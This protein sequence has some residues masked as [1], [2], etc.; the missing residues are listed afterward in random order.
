MWTQGSSKVMWPG[1]GNMNT[2][3]VYQGSGSDITP[4]T[5]AVFNNPANSSFQNSFPYNGYDVGDYNMDGT[6]IYQGSG[7]DIL[8]LTQA[9]FTNPMNGTYQLTYPISEQ[10]P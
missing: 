8:T 6:V 3:T 2:S 10:L 7:S 9:V 4:I 5:Q 1:N